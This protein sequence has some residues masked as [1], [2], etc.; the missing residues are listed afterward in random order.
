LPEEYTPGMENISESYY[1][2]HSQSMG[3]LPR[4]P[5]YRIHDSLK[6][7]ET[8]R[9]INCP[10]I[11]FHRAVQFAMLHQCLYLWIDQEC[12]NQCN[13]KDIEKH[14]QVMHRVYSESRWT[15]AVL[16][17]TMP[18]SRSVKIFSAFLERATVTGKSM[19]LENMQRVKMLMQSIPQDNWFSRTWAFQERLCGQNMHP[20]PY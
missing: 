5:D 12:I 3:S 11:V 2:K 20:C 4:I 10:P 14:L 19:P 13:N 6:L 9:S 17:W 15:I 18:S 7:E 1:W 16:S 8:P